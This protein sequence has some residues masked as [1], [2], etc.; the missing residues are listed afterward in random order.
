MKQPVLISCGAAHTV[1]C[2]DEGQAY[3]WGEGFYGALGFSKL[4]N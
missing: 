1:L 3:S 2:T 4:D